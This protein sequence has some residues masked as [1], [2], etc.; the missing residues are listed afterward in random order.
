[1][2]SSNNVETLMRRVG[3]WSMNNVLCYNV[4][5]YTIVKQATL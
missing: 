3:G 4:Q 2:T 5:N 1:M